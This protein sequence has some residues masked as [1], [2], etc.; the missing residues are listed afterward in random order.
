M[1]W[2]ESPHIGILLGMAFS[3]RTW[4]PAG[5]PPIPDHGGLGERKVR[6]GDVMTVTFI[7]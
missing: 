7:P 5:P 6:I 1:I 4:C 3:N 2:R